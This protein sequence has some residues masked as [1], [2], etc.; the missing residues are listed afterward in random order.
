MRTDAQ[1]MATDETLFQ[2]LERSWIVLQRS[3]GISAQHGWRG[4]W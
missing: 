3:R 4:D 2:P 1:A